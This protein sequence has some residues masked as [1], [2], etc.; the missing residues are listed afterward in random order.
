MDGSV[1]TLEASYDTLLIT[2]H[3]NLIC[4]SVD[5]S[6][7]WKGQTPEGAKLGLM[8]DVYRAAII[9]GLQDQAMPLL[10][11]HYGHRVVAAK[12]FPQNFKITTQKDI[13]LFEAYLLLLKKA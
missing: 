11:M 5:R 12:G 6:H 13:E 7:V 3:D 2:D 10:M 8:L 9:D 1:I 4:G